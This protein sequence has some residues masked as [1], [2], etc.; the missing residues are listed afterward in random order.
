MWFVW[1]CAAFAHEPGLSRVSVDGD[2]LVLQVARLDAADPMALLAT[3][4][5]SV[6]DRPCVV[7][8]ADVRPDDNGFVARATLDCPSGKE[9]TVD[10]G[11]FDTLPPGHR[12]VV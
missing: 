1:L 9:I 11:W 10:A 8:A 2:Q 5:A 12:T 4:R 7:G 3:T 6:G